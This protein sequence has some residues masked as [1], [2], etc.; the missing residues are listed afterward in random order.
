M[1][2]E[3]IER[4]VES[5]GSMG[6]LWGINR[7]MA[8]VHALLLASE[9]PLGLDDISE[10]LEIS[11]GNTSM[12]LKELRSWGVIRR[13]NRRGE[14]KDYYRPEADVWTM[15]FRI[16]AQ[17][18]RREFDP[19][20]EAV[21]TALEG[22][23]GEGGPVHRRL[24]EMEKL[25]GTMDGILIRLLADQDVSRAMLRFLSTQVGEQRG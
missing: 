4:F 25:L 6:V 1:N 24:D 23:A 17:R 3:S 10:R 2:R 22:F 18:K 8:C 15:L 5:W 13:V 9:Q 19:A 11:R 20:L 21:R 7:S 12:C 16:A 14:R